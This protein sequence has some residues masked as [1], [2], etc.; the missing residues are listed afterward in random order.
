MTDGCTMHRHI[1]HQREHT[2]AQTR[3]AAPQTSGRPGTHARAQTR[4]WA[5]RTP[6][7]GAR[8]G[9]SAAGWEKVAALTWHVSLLILIY[10]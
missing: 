4:P 7:P 5:A 10:Q 9:P 3:H 8:A 2:D 6:R 1:Q